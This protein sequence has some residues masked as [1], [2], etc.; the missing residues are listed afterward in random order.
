M[1]RYKWLLIFLHLGQG[2]IFESLQILD[3]YI[4][5]LDVSSNLHIFLLQV[6]K[7]IY[8]LRILIHSLFNLILL[9]H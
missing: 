9:S 5:R 1:V 3:L 8:E 4:F 7:I 6:I 2:L